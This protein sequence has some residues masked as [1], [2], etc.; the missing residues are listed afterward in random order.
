MNNVK[1]TIIDLLK[2][3]DIT[4]I[5]WRVEE[6][7]SRCLLFYNCQSGN[8]QSFIKRISKIQFCYC[9][10][11][12]DVELSEKNILSLKQEDWFDF[13]E[14]T[15]D[16]LYPLKKSTHLIGVTGTNGK[17]TAVDLIRQ[18]CV[19]NQISVLTLGTLGAYTGE[20]RVKDFGLT[21]P[22]YI[23]TRKTMHEH[24]RD[25]VAIEMSS[26]ALVQNR[27]GKLKFDAIIWTSF[28]QDHLDYHR[29]MEEYFNAKLKVFEYAK[30]GV[31]VTFSDSDPGLF[32]RIPFS[33]KKMISPDRKYQDPFLRIQYNQ[34]NFSL[35]LDA[36]KELNFQIDIKSPIVPTPGRFNIR[37]IQDAFIIVD[38][39][40]SPGGIESLGQALK[41]SFPEYEIVTLFGCGG[42]RDRGK[43]PLMGQ[44]ASAFSN[45]LIVTSDN[46]RGEKPRDIIEDVLKGVACEHTVLE[47]RREAIFWGVSYVREKK[48]V[49]LIAGKGHESFMEIQGKKIPFNDMNVVEDALDA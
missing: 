43:R 41:K 22:D 47:D 16:I 5:S 13:R 6:S 49:L 26:H 35:A 14:Q 34:D 29:T 24:S 33:H 11:L 31:M 48:A 38:F 21:T 37:P 3:Q 18:L 19:L 4:D 40:H 12:S 17:T 15:L 25:V 39:A 45:L 7:H 36:L 27:F 42:D 1:K 44:A 28:S 9:V 10:V 23:D 8:V 2:S 46:P 32:E 20:E 30:P